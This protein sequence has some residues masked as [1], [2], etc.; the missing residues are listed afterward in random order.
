[1]TEPLLHYQG[2]PV[3]TG[4]HNYRKC[5]HKFFWYSGTSRNNGVTYKF[6]VITGTADFM[7]AYSKLCKLCIFNV[8]LKLLFLIFL[9]LQIW[10]RLCLKINYVVI[11]CPK[12]DM[13]TLVRQYAEHCSCIKRIEFDYIY[14]EVNMKKIFKVWKKQY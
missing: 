14:E 7:K 6:A 5:Q 10:Y 9:D 3:T 11:I 1:M 2:F 12:K 4:F 8:E 13:L